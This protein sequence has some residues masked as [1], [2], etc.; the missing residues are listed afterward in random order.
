MTALLYTNGL[1]KRFGSLV[2]LQSVDFSIYPGE[3]VGLVGRSGAD[4]STLIK[5]LGGL[6]KADAGSIFYSGK[7]LQYPFDVYKLDIGIIH[8]QPRLVDQF[9]ITDNVFLGNEIGWSIL[10]RWLQIPNQR[11]MDEEAARILAEIGVSVRSLHQKVSNLSNEKRQLISIAKVLARQVRLVIINDPTLQLTHPYQQ[12]LLQFI[13]Q[14]QQKGCA[15]LFNSRN[16]DHLFAVSDRIMVLRQGRKVADVQADETNREEIVAALLGTVDRSSRTP[17]LWALDSY[18]R[19]RQQAEELRHNQ[20]FLRRDLAAQGSLNRELVDKLA[21]QVKALDSANLALQDAQRRLLTEREQERKHLARELHDQVIQDLLT[22]NYQLE[23]VE[24]QTAVTPTL[25]GEVHEM[26]QHVR[27]L[28]EDVRRICGILRPPTIDSLGLGAALKSYVREWSRRTGIQVTLTL[29]TDFG[30]LPEP[31]ELSIFRIVQ[32]GLNN[33]WKH[34]EASEVEVS[35]K[36]TSPR[37]MLISIADNG[38]G[39]SEQFDL[40]VLSRDGHYGLLGI[41]ERVALME[42]RLRFENL[43]EGGLL[44]QVEV[45]HPR[46]VKG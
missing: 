18:Y 4:A 3:V 10:G 20:S 43:A 5:L 40:A 31:I 17:A 12:K 37:M 30:R 36:P 27:H 25:S 35:L 2:A 28:V 7:Q 29:E 15:I 8:Q 24:D 26:G 13:R 14:W 6:L 22:L 19:A 45:P 42:G 33:V 39:L 32:E 11:K 44:M 38:S 9:D 16:L 23:E 34:A 1:S 46:A 41:S 21:E